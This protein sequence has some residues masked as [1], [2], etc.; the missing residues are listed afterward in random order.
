VSI[1]SILKKISCKKENIP[2]SHVAEIN[3]HT[4]RLIVGVIAVSLAFLTNLLSG[5]EIDSISA[6]YHFGGITR[7][8]FVGF[9]FAIAAFLLS[10]NGRCLH[11]AVLSKV[12]AFSALGVALFPCG[13]NGTYDEIIPSVHGTSALVMFLILAYFCNSFYQRA[14]KKEHK[15]AMIRAKIYA[16]SGFVIIG[17]ILLLFL[18]A[19]LGNA[20]STKL[21]RLVF[22]CEAAALVAFGISWLTASRVFPLITHPD[23][24]QSILLSK[25]E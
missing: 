9:L 7:D 4:T 18:D 24:R 16:I 17:S 19:L 5:G 2:A 11:E 12:A 15:E 10:Y 1:H 8:I 20:I 25:A 14:S 21:D 22:Y 13:C 6:S 23:E 3:H